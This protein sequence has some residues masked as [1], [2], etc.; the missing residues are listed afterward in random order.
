MFSSRFLLSCSP[1]ISG[2]HQNHPNVTS[3][4][5]SVCLPVSSVWVR[6]ILE[7][8]TW[9]EDRLPIIPSVG[10]SK[11]KLVKQ[12]CVH[13]LCKWADVNMLSLLACDWLKQIYLDKKTHF[14]FVFFIN[15]RNSWQQLSVVMVTV[16]SSDYWCYRSV[17]DQLV[18][19]VIRNQIHINQQQ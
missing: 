8:Q 7:L 14:I 10:G 3:S 15:W 2:S 1:L 6:P 4:V 19:L 13:T 11:G 9:P 16:L 12:L 18:L 5:V 17:T